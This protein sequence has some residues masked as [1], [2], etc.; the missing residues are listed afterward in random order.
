MGILHGV[1]IFQQLRVKASWTV[2]CKAFDDA[3]Y[4]L[5]IYYTTSYILKIYIVIAYNNI[6]M[7]YMNI[8]TSDFITCTI[9]IELIVLFLPSI[10]VSA[11]NKCPHSFLQI[12]R[13]LQYLD[14]LYTTHICIC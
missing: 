2:N 11:E 5:Y 9:S 8:S 13:Q 10:T 4:T 6:I 1:D 14:S 7:K 3:L 12:S